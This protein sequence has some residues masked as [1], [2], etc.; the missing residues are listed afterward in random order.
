MEVCVRTFV[1]CCALLNRSKERSCASTSP[2]R[3]GKMFLG[4]RMTERDDIGQ[5]VQQSLG[6]AGAVDTRVVPSNWL[7]SQIN[8]EP[9]AIDQALFDLMNAN[10]CMSWH[11]T[12]IDTLFVSL[13][14]E[15]GARDGGIPDIPVTHAFP[16]YDVSNGVKLPGCFALKKG[17]ATDMGRVLTL[18]EIDQHL[19]RLARRCCARCA[20]PMWCD[21]ERDMRMRSLAELRGGTVD[22]ALED[23][24]NLL[25]ACGSRSVQAFIDAAKQPAY[26]DV[27]PTPTQ[28]V[29]RGQVLAL[30]RLRGP[31]TLKALASCVGVKQSELESLLSQLVET[32]VVKSKRSGRWPRYYVGDETSVDA[33]LE[34]DIL[35]ALGDC[36]APIRTTAL[37]ASIRWDVPRVVRALK[38]LRGRGH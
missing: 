11:D 9:D 13:P 24:V 8:H 10:A 26:A 12:R 32:G 5:L 23:A 1:S 33:Q 14:R 3:R 29:T 36:N 22:A 38:R 37:A 31:A 19:A 16:L 25:S 21:E 15:I 20:W 18:E 35:S 4:E 6:A 30:V 2:V 28:R 34:A 17:R 7:H 27:L